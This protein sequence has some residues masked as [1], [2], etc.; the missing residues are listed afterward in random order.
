[1]LATSHV[2]LAGQL[3]DSELTMNRPRLQRR[4]PL[5]VA[6][7]PLLRPPIEAP[8]MPRRLG[9]A[10]LQYHASVSLVSSRHYDGE[11]AMNQPRLQRRRALEVAAMPLLRPPIEAPANPR[12][13]SNAPLQHSEVAGSASLVSSRQHDDELAMQ[14]PR[15]QRR[16]ALGVAA[17]PLF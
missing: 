8:A 7:T 6:A 13:L 1:M 5:G 3:T 16:R 9:I 11:F 10:P 12:R 2:C 17:T 14:Q 4:R 15:L